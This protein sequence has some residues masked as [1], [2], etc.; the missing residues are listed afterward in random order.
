MARDEF[1]EA[2]NKYFLQGKF[3]IRPL[4]R[5][6]FDQGRTFHLT[7]PDPIVWIK[8]RY[9][10][11]AIESLNTSRDTWR[12]QGTTFF[13]FQLRPNKWLFSTSTVA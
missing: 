7:L 9:T 12:I 3:R 2:E 1:Y 10:H 13:S 8:V 5:R 6:S 11:G 4:I